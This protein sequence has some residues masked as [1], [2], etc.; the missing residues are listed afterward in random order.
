MAE[1]E[2]GLRTGLLRTGSLRTGSVQGAS[3]LG[4]QQDEVPEA[5][6]RQEQRQKKALSGEL[7]KQ[8]QIDAIQSLSREEVERFNDGQVFSAAD[9]SA[10]TGFGQFRTLRAGGAD[11]PDL[12]PLKEEFIA[13]DVRRWRV[14]VVDSGPGSATIKLKKNGGRISVNLRG[15]RELTI[16]NVNAEFS[17]SLDKRFYL[18][19][20]GYLPSS[21][22]PEDWEVRLLCDNEWDHSE[23]FKQVGGS[24]EDADISA[25]EFYYPIATILSYDETLLEEEDPNLINL[26]EEVGLM[27]RQLAPDS[28]LVILEGAYY[29]EERNRAY[30]VQYAYP[31]VGPFEED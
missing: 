13:E 28:N 29:R 27:I 25:T 11:E 20:N 9:G 7:G 2:Q 17:A 26:G 1:R 31:P 22:L 16:T 12:P 4:R 18:K 8:A 21:D 14:S 10:L 6:K 5:L 3:G 15:D 24:G 19:F 30:Y 23:P